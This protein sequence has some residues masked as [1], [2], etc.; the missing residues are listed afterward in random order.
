MKT[1]QQ[2]KNKKYYGSPIRVS[3]EEAIAL[4]AAGTH[5]FVGKE[6]WKKLVR[7]LHPDKGLYSLGDLLKK[8]LDRKAAVSIA[9]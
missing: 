8:E 3:N 7:D 4:V 2:H 9:A 6:R 5:K 1:V